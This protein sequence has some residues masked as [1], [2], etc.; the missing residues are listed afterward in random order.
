[1]GVDPFRNLIYVANADDN[2]VSVI[3]GSTNAVIKNV[4]V[5]GGPDAIAVN[6]STGSVYVANLDDNNVSVI[7]E[8]TIRVVKNVSV[9]GYPDALALDAAKNIVYVANADDN[10][11]SVINGSTNAV[12][13]SVTVGGDPDALAVDSSANTVYVA[14]SYDDTV[15]VINGS[16]NKVI[17][18]VPVGASPT[19]VAVDS[20]TGLVYV[21]NFD[22]WTVSVINGSD[23]SLVTTVTA[24]GQGPDAIALD[25]VT[26]GVYVVNYYQDSLSMM[27]GATNVVVANV[28]VGQSPS[29][30][31]VNPLTNVVYA[32]NIDSNSVSVVA[33]LKRASQTY[34]VCSSSS[35]SIGESVACA[36]LIVGASPSGQVTWDS[37]GVGSFVS[38]SGASCTISGDV[39]TVRWQ[40]SSPFPASPVRI[41]ATFRGDVNNKRS[42]SQFQVS[43]TVAASSTSVVC[44]PQSV[45][46]GSSTECTGS[47][48]GYSPTGQISWSS[49]G[50]VSF[51]GPTCTLSAGNCSVSM[52][53]SA[54]G[55]SKLAITATYTGDQNNLGSSGTY[56]IRTSAAF[57]TLL[58]GAGVAALAVIVGTAFYLVRKRKR[59]AT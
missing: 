28:T 10:T 45:A 6:P 1:V 34:V 17:A 8:S 29:A 26:N 48:T 53:P 4:T 33:G 9:G 14:N 49:N 25:E 24:T 18:T 47:V 37:T 23:Y 7:D 46:A 56:L 58:A 5:G 41:M 57:P 59:R 32:A 22:D 50:T 36:A 43:L 3:N 38:T 40:P 51:S 52:V 13:K 19:G 54:A 30:V 2:T 11:V 44:T 39:C 16:T 42:S 27:D 20:A 21:T 35:V 31:A 55:S 15:S 12:I